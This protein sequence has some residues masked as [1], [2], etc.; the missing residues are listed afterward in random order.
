MES[1]RPQTS[2]NDL[3]AKQRIRNSAGGGMGPNYK[4]DTR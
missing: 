4:Q 1:P 3:Q 2:G